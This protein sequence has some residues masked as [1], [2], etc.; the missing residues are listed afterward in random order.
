MSHWV[1]YFC[2]YILYFCFHLTL[3]IKVDVDIGSELNPSI[4]HPA[5]LGYW[6]SEDD[7]IQRSLIKPKPPPPDKK[8]CS[9]YEFLHYYI[10]D[11][12]LPAL[13]GCLEQVG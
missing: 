10:W 9:N 7:K 3:Q 12:L 11:T 8:T 2:L 6:V 13:S 4:G 5:A 1:P